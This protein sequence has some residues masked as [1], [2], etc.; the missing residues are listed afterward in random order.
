MISEL[1][2]EREDTTMP[3]PNTAA[4]PGFQN[5]ELTK[6]KW[7]SGADALLLLIQFGSLSDDDRVLML[8][9]GP[10]AWRSACRKWHVGEVIGIDLTEPARGLER[11]HK[12]CRM[13]CAP[14]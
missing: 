9:A 3:A 14:P 7:D 5:T 12:C 10:K 11:D 6:N 13:R 1:T 4:I 2:S 8:A